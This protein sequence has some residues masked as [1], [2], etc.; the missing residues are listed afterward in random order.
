MSYL[1]THAELN[2]HF[3]ISCPTFNESLLEVNTAL[4][5]QKHGLLSAVLSVKRVL[6]QS[7]HG[8][9]PT[10]EKALTSSV[11]YSTRTKHAFR[12]D[13]KHAFT[14]CIRSFLAFRMIRRC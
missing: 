11:K 14:E 7:S 3:A 13:L 1:Q 4:L 10:D 6:I 8:N 12:Y 9:E 5:V 2:P